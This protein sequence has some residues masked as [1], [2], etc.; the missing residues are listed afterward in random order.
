M[1]R[2]RAKMMVKGRVNAESQIGTI[3]PPFNRHTSIL[4]LHEVLSH[5]VLATE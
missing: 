5:Q 2:T 4:N 3:E 1:D